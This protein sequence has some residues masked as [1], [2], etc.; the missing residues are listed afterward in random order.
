[1]TPAGWYADPSGRY[2]HRHWDGSQWTRCV[3]TG[4]R[5]AVDDQGDPSVAQPS[6]GQP[7]PGWYADPR[8]SGGQRYWDGA[9]WTGQLAWSTPN[10]RQ[11]DEPEAPSPRTS[12]KKGVARQVRHAGAPVSSDDSQGGTLFTEQVLVF[13]QKARVLR[14][15]SEYTIFR[16]DGVQLGAIEEVG[17][18]IGTR[19][20]V[21]LSGTNERD[22][23]RRFQIIDTQGR[24]LLKMGRSESGWFGAKGQLR[25]EGPHG[26]IGL[27]RQEST[28]L[29]GELIETAGAFGV[30][31]GPKMARHAVG[32]VK[33]LVAGAAARGA[34][35]PMLV[36]LDKV[37]DVGRA[38]FALE[39]GGRRL[40]SIR[41]KG[42]AEREFSIRDDEDLEVGRI[43]RTWEG[44]AKSFTKTDH[45][46]LV[47][48]RPLTDPLRTLIVAAALAIDVEL[49][50]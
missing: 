32:G 10:S 2:E 40:G 15:T 21:R 4:G 34:R 25:V 50:E 13:N 8:G 37:D 22:R 24:L 3:A 23:E 26:P 44:L 20:A 49:R 29:V 36:G 5:Q 14:S 48:N 1:M 31:Y 17:L 43:T 47:M 42:S 35:V 9:Q 11:A 16:Q 46:V 30:L 7:S 27:I 33:G 28:G 19:L 38:R 6:G 39:A 12:K 45:Y 41:T 18:D